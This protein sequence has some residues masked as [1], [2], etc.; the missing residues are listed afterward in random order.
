MEG[1]QVLVEVDHEK[2]QAA[3]TRFEPLLVMSDDVGIV[4]RSFGGQRANLSIAAGI[5][6]EEED[7]G[8]V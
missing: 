1:R 4:S 7:R 5:S 2:V 6:G 3:G 8:T